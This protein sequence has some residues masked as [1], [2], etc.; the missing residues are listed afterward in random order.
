MRY[1]KHLAILAAF[2]A[3]MSTGCGDDGGGK[4][5][6]C[7]P[8]DPQCPEGQVCIYE[9]GA[10]QATCVESCDPE[11]ANPCEAG[12]SCDPVQGGGH[13]CFKPVVFRGMVFDSSTLEAIQGAHVAAADEGGLV[14]TDIA[15]TDA[16]GSYELAVPVTRDASG[17]P[18]EAVF[19]LRVSAQE[20]MPY[21][22]GI[23][24]AIPIEVVSPLEEE[25]AYSV[26]NPTTDVALIPLEGATGDLGIIE[27]RVDADRPA[28]ALVVA[29]GGADLP[30]PYGFADRSGEFT[31]FNVPAGAYQV[32][33]YKASIQLEPADVELAAGETLQDVVLSISEEPLAN[34]SGQVSIVDAPGGAATSVVLVPESTF[35]EIFA[36]GV[37]P[38]GLRDPEPGVAPDVTG[39]FT[40]EGVPNGRYVVLA[41]FENDMLVRDPDPGIAGTQIVHIEVPPAEGGPDVNI[42]EAFKVTEAL[43]IVGPGADGPEAVDPAQTVTFVW[44][45]DASEEYYSLVVYNAYGELVWE[46]QNVARVTGPETVEVD[47]AG[48]ELQS[49]MYYQWRA[50]SYRMSGPISL[51]ED[52]RGVF[53]VPSDV[54]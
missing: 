35:I 27:G 32:H 4:K 30:A 10:D 41:A 28:G 24:P 6:T 22:F 7:D 19:T 25:D 9:D 29:E 42:G 49:G 38:P 50:T 36:R 2:A 53:F 37:V 14:A 31:I 11:A 13:A 44:M 40:I 21:P 23:R 48:P 43:E 39:E 15:I 8:A 1:L 47:Y 3:M 51:T 5:Q 45:D 26:Q 33:G 54:Q 34:V 20:Y 16:L 52:L 46:D 17:V 12:L 18:E